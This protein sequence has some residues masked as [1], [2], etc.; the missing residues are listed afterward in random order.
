MRRRWLTEE[1]EMFRDSVRRFLQD[2]AEPHMDEWR[3][4]GVVDRAVFRKAGALGF[5]FMWAESEFGG[6]GLD[7]FRY[8]Q[9]LIEELY[10]AGCGDIFIPAHN[11]LVGRYLGRLAS[12]EQKQRFYPGCIS[13]D[14]I[15]GI[16]MTEPDTGSDLAAMKTRAVDCGDHWRLS[17]AKTYISN[18]IIGDLFV[19]AAKTGEV[20]DRQTGLFL[21][22]RDM[23]GFSRG[24]NLEKLGMKAQDTAELFFDEVRIPKNN[25]LGDPSRG[26]YYLMENLA[27]E[28]LQSATCSLANARAALDETL[29]FTRERLVFGE[30][31]A[32]FQNTRFQFASMATDMEAAQVFLDRCVEELNAGELAAEDA[33]KVKL[34]CSELEGRVVDQCLQFHGGAGYMDEYMISR[35][36]ADARISRI[37]AGTSEIMREIIARK[38]GLDFRGKH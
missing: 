25:E 16:A 35:R 26:F 12:T 36:Y 38:M 30:P 29:A 28:R 10:R 15:L 33:A 22:E 24:R 2:E 14:T 37:Y 5:L 7:D 20:G 4:Q 27:E 17:G 8:D 6:L 18:G 1:H 31:V 21:V 19:V 23:P 13:G 11:R 34:F 32:S 3:R 9:V